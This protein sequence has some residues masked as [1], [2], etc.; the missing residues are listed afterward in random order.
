MDEQSKELKEL[1][2]YYRG[3]LG[4]INAPRPVLEAAERIITDLDG[5]R[6]V[7]PS[8]LQMVRSFI[9]NHDTANPDYESMVETL[10]DYE[11]RIS[12]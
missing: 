12:P 8:R 11:E 7:E 2:T 6:P 3:Y 1:L 5:E 9:E 10:K 4:N